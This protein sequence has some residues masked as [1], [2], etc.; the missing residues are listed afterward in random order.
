MTQAPVMKFPE[1]S[2]LFILDTDASNAAIAAELARVQNG[3]EHVIAFG[4]FGLSAPQRKYC[5]TTKKLLAIIRFTRQ[6]R[7]YLLGRQF[8]IRT[9]HSSLTWIL[10]FKNAD[11]QLARWPE[12]L[13][14]Y[15]MIIQHRAGAKHVNAD[16][17]SRPPDECNCYQAGNDLSK[18]PCGECNYC[19]RM[20][21]Q[22]EQFSLD[23]DDVLP[24]TVLDPLKIMNADITAVHVE[25][26]QESTLHTPVPN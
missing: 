15:D 2:G 1:R 19:T 24:S 25:D 14:Q 22:W 18:L 7:H 17:L 5:T 21:K 23:V 20:S 12:E 9:D 26:A 6:F 10:R 13:A 11:G 8:V 16:W 4:S 3:D